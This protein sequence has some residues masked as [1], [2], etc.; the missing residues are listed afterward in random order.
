MTR[1]IMP[2]LLM[3]LLFRPP[4]ANA[5]DPFVLKKKREA[6]LI[7]GGAATCL[8]GALISLRPAPSGIQNLDQERIFKPDRFA[9]RLSYET[10]AHA[11][12][13]L[14]VACM[15]LPLTFVSREHLA[16][17]GLMIVE[18]NLLCI[19][20]TQACKGIFRRPRPYAYRQEYRGKPLSR[21]A[22]QS[23][24]SAHTS[25]AFNG[26]FLAGCVYQK[27]HPQSKSARAVWISGLTMAAATGAC[28]VLSGNHFPTDVAAAALVGAFT[29]WLIPRLH[30]GGG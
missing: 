3:L 23:F 12:D 2:C 24:F 11:S 25:V 5:D 30:L 17:D 29:G 15:G 16:T 10:A 4:F 22:L 14:Q 7:G 8:F 18:S 27:R 21:Y 19:G 20:I 6:A 9:V 13:V 26:A 1:R 28:R